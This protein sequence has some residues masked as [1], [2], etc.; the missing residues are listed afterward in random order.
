MI[1]FFIKL[2]IESLLIILSNN[3]NWASINDFSLINNT[4]KREQFTKKCSYKV[5]KNLMKKDNLYDHNNNL[6]GITD[7]NKIN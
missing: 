5:I 6:L 4:H 7:F 3:S 2:L 1:Y